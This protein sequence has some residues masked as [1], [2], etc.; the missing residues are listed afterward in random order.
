MKQRQKPSDGEIQSYMDFEHLLASVKRTAQ[1]SHTV[2]ILKWSVPVLFVTGLITWF[3]LLNGRETPAFRQSTNI[4]KQDSASTLNLTPAVISI[5]TAASLSEEISDEA[6]ENKLQPQVVE[7]EKVEEEKSVEEVRE[8]AYIQAEPVGGYAEL[9]SYFNSKLLYPE[10]AMKDSVQGI[11]TISFV[12]NAAG[13][14][15]KIEVVQSLGEPFEKESR[16]LIE[17]MPEWKPATLNG[18]PVASK[19]TIP[20]TFQIKKIKE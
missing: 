3:F 19:I 15:E 17:N 18:K 2:T 14:P 6:M 13:K 1:P 5:D 11:Q 4:E 8:S 16:R 10:E 12:I 9:Y 7:L 20:L